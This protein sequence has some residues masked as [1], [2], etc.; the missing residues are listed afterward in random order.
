MNLNDD[1]RLIEERE[2]LISIPND[3]VSSPQAEALT[4]SDSKA[5][6]I[7]DS[8]TESENNKQSSTDTSNSSSKTT[9]LPPIASTSISKSIDTKS[10][11]S[12][13]TNNND[14]TSYIT[15]T[16]ALAPLQT[17]GNSTKIDSSIT[18]SSSPIVE[19]NKNNVNSKFVDEII[20][21]NSVSPSASIVHQDPASIPMPISKEIN[22]QP[23][24]AQVANRDDKDNKSQEPQKDN[25]PNEHHHHHHNHSRESELPPLTLEEC[26]NEYFNNSITVKRHLERRRT[27]D[28]PDIQPSVKEDHEAEYDEYEKMGILIQV[29]I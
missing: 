24:K 11:D 5:T 18:P 23:I 21:S 25:T 14:N 29:Q 15:K 26:L 1:L 3:P 6:T 16:T 13:A 19:V 7:G 9:I 2:L 28:R 8:N 27:I 22:T 4:L 12:N 10:N 17:S 20:N